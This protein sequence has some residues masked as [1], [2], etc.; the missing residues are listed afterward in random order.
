MSLPRPPKCCQSFHVLPRELGP[1]CQSCK[2]GLGVEVGY[3]VPAP[4]VLSAV[5]GSVLSTGP[6]S[7]SPLICLGNRFGFQRTSRPSF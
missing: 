6:S 3:P 2:P 5:S 7:G 1:R 4:K